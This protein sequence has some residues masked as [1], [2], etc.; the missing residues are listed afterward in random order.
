MWVYTGY[1]GRA[2]EKKIKEFSEKREKT[3]NLK[4]ISEYIRRRRQRLVAVWREIAIHGWLFVYK[5]T[6]SACIL[7]CV[8][9]IQ[10]KRRAVVLAVFTGCPC[11]LC[12]FYC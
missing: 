5:L 3:L 6:R 12:F 7:C 1:D 2:R 10:Q 9:A 8:C 11:R 4:P